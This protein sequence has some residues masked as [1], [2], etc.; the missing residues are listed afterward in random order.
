MLL[1]SNH[2][3]YI[4]LAAALD[5][6]PAISGEETPGSRVSSKVPFWGR[7]ASPVAARTETRERRAVCGALM[8]AE[9]LSLHGRDYSGFSLSRPQSMWLSRPWDRKESGL[10]ALFAIA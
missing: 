7:K 6:L 1:G 2:I 5:L 4:M 10:T 8:D 3:S 9:A